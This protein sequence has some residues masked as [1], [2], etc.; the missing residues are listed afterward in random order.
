MVLGV[1]D[2]YFLSYS[3][4]E[5]ISLNISILL[6]HLFSSPKR[7]EITLLVG[8]HCST[9]SIESRSVQISEAG[10]LV[11]S[12]V[13]ALPDNW[14]VEILGFLLCIPNISKSRLIKMCM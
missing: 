13:L 1:R 12:C 6:F 9:F 11:Y 10:D 2:A 8:N 4:K 3:V 7:K 5:R 14:E